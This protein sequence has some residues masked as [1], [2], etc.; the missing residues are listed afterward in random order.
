MENATAEQITETTITN[1]ISGNVILAIHEFTALLIAYFN[2]K[3]NHKYDYTYFMSNSVYRVKSIS[4]AHVE[5]R[6]VT[7]VLEFDYFYYDFNLSFTDKN[8]N[9]N[10]F[11]QK[12]LME[13]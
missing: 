9:E 13:N 3:F 5:L 10:R 2:S 7:K 12:Y 1:Q 4:D 8:D 11:I 6:C